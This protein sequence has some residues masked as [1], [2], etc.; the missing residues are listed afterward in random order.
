MNTKPK[1]S[2]LAATMLAAVPDGTSP[3]DCLIACCIMAH[4]II[5]ERCPP[6]CHRDVTEK[7]VSDFYNLMLKEV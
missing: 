6:D 1:P 7:F 2:D 4:L 3:I 5:E